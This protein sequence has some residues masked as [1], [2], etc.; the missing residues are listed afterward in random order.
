[1]TE[2]LRIENLCY[3]YRSSWTLA[4]KPCLRGVSLAVSEGEAFGFLGPNGAGETT[5]I[6]CILGLIQPTAGTI[7]IFG[8]SSL[9]SSSRRAVGYLPEQPYFYDYLTV[10][11]ALEL[12]GALYGLHGSELAEAAA[13]TLARVGLSERSGAKMRT[14]SKGLVQRAA[15]AQAIIARPKLLILDEPFSGLDPIGRREFR[16]IFLSLKSEG[17]TLFMSSHALSDIETICGRASIMVGGLVREVIDIAE[18]RMSGRDFF[19]LYLTIPPGRESEILDLAP[20]FSRE[21]AATRF[22]I[23]GRTAA[24]AVLK[25]ALEIGAVIHEFSAVDAGLERFFVETVERGGA[26][27]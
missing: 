27:R 15:L 20:S 22:Q 17:T 12:Y 25:R 7:E 19:E 8:R 5:T 11:E 24:D 23:K 9:Q 2:A 14:L 26:A 21:G 18:T 10:K 13:S 3:G 6:K 4:R 1:M 16:E